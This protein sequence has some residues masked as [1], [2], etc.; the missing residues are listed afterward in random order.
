MTLIEQIKAD[1][2][3][4]RKTKDSVKV[5]LLATLL[6][7]AQ[8]IGKNAGNRE[9]TDSEVI[10]VVKK[11]IKNVNELLA[12]APGHVQATAEISVL[13]NYLPKQMSAD[14]IRAALNDVP[15]QKGTMMQHLKKN[16]NGQY[17]G[18]QASD[19]IDAILLTS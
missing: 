16:F 8:M 5:S 2:L 13:E 3:T 11:F 1:Y 15:R 17:D 18:K 9:T 6:G 19:L 10:A 14:E 7:E 12:V 4:A